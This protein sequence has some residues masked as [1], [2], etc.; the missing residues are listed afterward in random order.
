MPRTAK[1]PVM[2]SLEEIFRMAAI[3]GPENVF[4]TDAEY[5]AVYTGGAPPIKASTIAN[6]RTRD[7]IRSKTIRGANGNP[8]T[9]LSDALSERD[10]LVGKKASA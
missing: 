3:S 1:S 8:L 4:I 10:R 6:K 2:R 5:G 9:R 7:F